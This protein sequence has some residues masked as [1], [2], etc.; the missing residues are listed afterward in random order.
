MLK[1]CLE[2]E[3]IE[4]YHFTYE[5]WQGGRVDRIE[6]EDF[7][8]VP[9]W[10]ELDS[11]KQLNQIVLDPGVVFS[12]GLHPTTRDCLRALADVA[13]TRP[14]ESVMDFGTGTGILAVAAVLFWCCEDVKLY[15]TNMPEV[16]REGTHNT[17]HRGPG[18]YQ[19]IL[20]HLDLWN[21]KA[22]PLPRGNTPPNNIEPHLDYSNSQLPPP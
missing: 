14:F 16:P 5:Q 10:G 7:V 18:G 22:R 4:H 11:N 20:K 17:V 6:V 3:L 15:P 2:L 21:L 12:N 19:K 1:K 9:P 8:I 13:R